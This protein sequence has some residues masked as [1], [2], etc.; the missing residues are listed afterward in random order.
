MKK[1]YLENRFLYFTIF[2]LVFFGLYLCFV[3]GYGSDE[4]TLPMIYVFEARLKDGTFIS[5]RFTGYPIPEMGIG[6]LS[7]YLGSWAA[8][9]TT[10][11]FY[12]IGIFLIYFSFINKFEPNKFGLFLILCLSSPVLFFDNLEPID[13]SWAFLFFSIGT[14]FYSKKFFEIAILAFAFCVGCR[15]NFLIFCLATVFFYNFDDNIEIKRKIM[16]C[17]SIFIIGGLFYLPVWFFHAFELH[18]LSAGR[19][20]EQGFFGLFAR[21]SY[22]TWIAFGILQTFVISFYILKNFKNFNLKENQLLIILI[23]INL[24]IFFYIPAEISY[25]Q[26]AIIFFYLFLIKEFNKKIILTLILLNFISWFINLQILEIKYR[27]NSLCAAKQALTASFVLKLAPGA[28][29]NFFETRKM[30]NCWINDGNERGKRILQ[31]KSTKI[32]K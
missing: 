3:G 17:F 7:Y 21:F 24:L 20:L 26:P 25:L 27:D 10:F 31:G 22:K 28:I 9:S 12:L 6:F 1:K 30:I 13:Y 11:L 19:P 16:I 4:D 5:S 32:T 29:N 2:S 15:I 14:Y 8:N 23:I 18:W